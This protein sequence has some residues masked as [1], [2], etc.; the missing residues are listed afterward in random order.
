MKKI[1]H[2]CRESI[3]LLHVFKII[4]FLTKN[5]ITAHK[6]ISNV[7]FFVINSHLILILKFSFFM[8]YKLRIRLTILLN[9]KDIAA[10]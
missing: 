2:R 3:N 10:Q 5:K 4:W 7:I 1:I 9:P 6:I 8:A